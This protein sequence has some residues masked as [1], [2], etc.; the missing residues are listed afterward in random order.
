MDT[1]FE[2]TRD[3]LY[4][5]NGN[6]KDDL[7]FAKSCAAKMLDFVEHK[8]NTIDH[9]T[10]YKNIATQSTLKEIYND[11][12]AINYICSELKYLVSFFR[13]KSDLLDIF[14]VTRHKAEEHFKAAENVASRLHRHIVSP[15]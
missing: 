7:N 8:R 15:P 4:R 14:D 9:F 2:F 11:L 13:L 5:I 10:T 12:T 3:A 1:N 6:G